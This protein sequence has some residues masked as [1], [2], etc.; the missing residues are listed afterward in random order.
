MISR[1]ITGGILHSFNSGRIDA[2]QIISYVRETIAD[3][4]AEVREIVEFSDDAVIDMTIEGLRDVLT[5]VS[6]EVNRSDIKCTI[7]YVRPKSPELLP[8]VTYVLNAITTFG[9]T[10]WIAESVTEARDIFD[11]LPPKGV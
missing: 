1:S 10:S 5:V 7:I 6:R 2:E 9:E 8:Y 4:P 11:S 3:K